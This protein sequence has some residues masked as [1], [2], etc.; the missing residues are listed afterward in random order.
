M[1]GYNG[2]KNFAGFC[3]KQDNFVA[4]SKRIAESD[5]K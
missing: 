3:L 2:V 5:K 4:I 1:Y